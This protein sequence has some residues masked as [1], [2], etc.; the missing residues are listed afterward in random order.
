MSTMRLPVSVGH[1]RVA[2]VG[3]RDR[4]APGSVRPSASVALVIVDAVPMVM[5]W[6]GERAMP[7]STSRQSS[8]V[9]LPARSSAQYFQVSLPLPRNWP[10]QSPRSIGPAGMKIAGRFIDDRAH[11]QRR[12]GLVAAAHQHAAVDR[13]GAQ[14]LLG[15]HRQQVAVEHRRRLLERLGQRDRRHLDRE[16]AGLPDAALDL[17]GALLEVR[18]AGVDVAPGV[19]DRD[20]RLAGVVAAVIAHLRG[21]RAVA[22]RAHVLHAVP[23]VAAQLLGRLAPPRRG[24]VRFLLGHGRSR[25]L[26]GRF[27][28]ISG[29]RA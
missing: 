17:L 5:Q 11:D 12:R 10:R 26:S 24:A 23:A 14:Q 29:R 27:A 7:S 16:A 20:H 8:S 15:L 6:P 19:D 1:L 3:R 25:V 21:A 9:M 18:V 28:P 2:R 4:R 13:I 22:E